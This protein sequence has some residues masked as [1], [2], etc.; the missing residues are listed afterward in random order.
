MAI[1]KKPTAAQRLKIRKQI[2]FRE[3]VIRWCLTNH[4]PVA[5]FEH[6]FHD[7]RKWRFDIAWPA[8]KVAVEIHGGLFRF[9][10]HSRGKGFLDDRE[11]IAT[12]ISMGWKV[13]EVAPSGKH[14]NTLYSPQLLAWLKG[15]L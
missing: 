11:K 14:P 1:A 8:S 15:S 7:T 3:M 2:A 10:H 9:G 5:E 4:L 12:A 13:F 6:R